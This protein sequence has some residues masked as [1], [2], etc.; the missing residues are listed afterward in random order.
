MLSEELLRAILVRHATHDAGEVRTF[1]LADVLAW[2]GV[3]VPS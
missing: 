3:E 2:N 1:A